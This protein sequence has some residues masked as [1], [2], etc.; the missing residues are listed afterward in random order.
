LNSINNKFQPEGSDE[1]DRP[2]EGLG[3]KHPKDSPSMRPRR[4]L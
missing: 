3:K 4:D 2:E 1:T